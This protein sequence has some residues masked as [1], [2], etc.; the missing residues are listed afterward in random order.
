MI[1]FRKQLKK[2]RDNG[3]AVPSEGVA[4]HKKIPRF[5]Y[6]IWCKKFD[7]QCKPSVCKKLR[8]NE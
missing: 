4:V 8:E 3:I 2:C 6:G 7:C 5:V 1:S